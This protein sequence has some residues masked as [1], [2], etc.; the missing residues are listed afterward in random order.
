MACAQGDRDIDQGFVVLL[1]FIFV[2]FAILYL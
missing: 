2:A 1:L